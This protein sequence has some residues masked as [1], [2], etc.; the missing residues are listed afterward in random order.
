[1]EGLDSIIERHP[2]FQT[3]KIL[4]LNALAANE[5]IIASSLKWIA[6][7]QPVVVWAHGPEQNQARPSSKPDVY[8]RLVDIGYRTAVIYDGSGRYVETISL[9]A[10]QQLSDLTGY[11]TEQGS[12]VMYAFHED[13]LDIRGQVREISLAQ[14]R[15]GGGVFPL[16]EPSMLETVGGQIAPHPSVILAS[17]LAAREAEIGRLKILLTDANE[18]WA[19][20]EQEM[21]ASLALRVARSLS[22]ILRPLMALF[23]TG[24]GRK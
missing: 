10:R 24:S 5:E 7:A 18:G 9:D 19:K 13:D 16:S 2:K 15:N 12:C 1:M 21:R 17:D 4:N 22:W 3:A 20:L 11:F 6:A 8:R 23:S 14:G